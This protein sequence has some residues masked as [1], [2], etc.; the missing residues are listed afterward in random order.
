MACLLENISLEDKNVLDLTENS[1]MHMILKLDKL[2]IF[3][4]EIFIFMIV[5]DILENSMKN[6]LSHKD[7]LNHIKMINGLKK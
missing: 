3:M 4:E 5:M 1:L 6:S 2:S 7:H